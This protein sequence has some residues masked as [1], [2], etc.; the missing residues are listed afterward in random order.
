MRSRATCPAIPAG[1]AGTISCSTIRFDDGMISP[2]RAVMILVSRSLL[3][4]KS[5]SLKPGQDLVAEEGKLVDVVDQR[6]GDSGQT[7]LAQVDQLPGDMVGIADDGQAPHPL[8]VAGTQLLKLLRRRVLRRDVLEREDRVDRRPVRV[9]HDRI[10]IIV[11]RL[12]LGRLA[13]DD[14]DGIDAEFPALLFGLA[15]GGGDSL[16]R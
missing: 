6:N 4:A 9:L 7:R 11:L 10:V 14:A 16:R 3:V 2:T 1:K 12:L 13:G 8:S 15:L 5:R